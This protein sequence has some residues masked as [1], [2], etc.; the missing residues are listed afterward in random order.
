MHSGPEGLR[1]EFNARVSSKG[2]WETYL[3]AF[4]DCVVEAKVESVIGAYNRTNGEHCCRNILRGKWKF[5][6]H[7]VSDCWAIWDFHTKHMVTSTAPESAAL[8]LKA[9]CDVN[10]GNTYLHILQALQENLIT[11]EDITRAAIWLLPGLNL[12][13]LTNVNMIIFHTL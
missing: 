7:V 9:G 2:L 4:E 11:E 6:G 1:H 13:C 3:P 5:E 12:E 8:A 10:C